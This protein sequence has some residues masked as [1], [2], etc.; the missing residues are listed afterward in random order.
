MSKHYDHKAYTI[1]I[2]GKC[3][4][5]FKISDWDYDAANDECGACG[6]HGFVGLRTEC[7]GCKVKIDI[8]FRSW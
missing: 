8:D 7:P 5:R 6:S 2:C 4:K 1:V 3:G